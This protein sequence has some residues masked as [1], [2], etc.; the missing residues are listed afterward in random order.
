MRGRPPVGKRRAPRTSPASAASPRI[1]VPRQPP[2]W[3]APGLGLVL[4]SSICISSPASACP[5]SEKTPML[6]LVMQWSL[7]DVLFLKWNLL[8]LTNAGTSSSISGL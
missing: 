5:A 1:F 2:A 4:G 6:C 8:R 7:Q 3:D